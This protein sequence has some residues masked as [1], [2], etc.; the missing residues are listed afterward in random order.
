MRLKIEDLKLKIATKPS[1]GGFTIVET[2]VA[3]TILMIAIAG[4]LTVATQALHAAQD[5]KNQMIAT[6]LA[7]ETIEE[8][9]NF[10]DNN[11]TTTSLDQLFGGYVPGGSGGNGPWF[12]EPNRYGSG[13]FI[14]GPCTQ[15]ST[16]CALS[17]DPDNGYSVG[18]FARTPFRRSFIATQVSS[19]EYLITVTVTWS[20]GTADNQ[21]RIQDLLTANTR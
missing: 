12:I 21:I 5:A 10:K 20:S 1:S 7:Q 3:V 6:N 4:P 15:V 13:T 9:R 16:V 14:T 17:I 11:I 2:L 18:Q 8:L 19:S